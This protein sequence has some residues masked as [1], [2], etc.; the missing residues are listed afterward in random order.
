MTVIH[1]RYADIPL[2]GFG[3]YEQIGNIIIV[4]KKPRF[5]TAQKIALTTSIQ[6]KN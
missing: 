6:S 4:R 3:R 5:G 1:F 2:R